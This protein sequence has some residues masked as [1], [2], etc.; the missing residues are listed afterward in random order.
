MGIQVGSGIKLFHCYILGAI[1][2]SILSVLPFIPG[3]GGGFVFDDK[4]NIVENPALQFSEL[5]VENL[6]YAA[7]SFYAGG[8]S[9]ALAMLTFALDHWRAGLDPHAFK[10]TNLLIHGLTTLV[11]AFFF[12]CI[13]LQ[14]QWSARRAAVAALLLA[15]VW[16]VHPLQVS[17]VLYVVQR[18]QTLG[19][20][21][22]ILAL[23]SYL[24]MRQLQI[25]GEFGRTFGLLSALLWAMALACK[26]D[27][28]LLPAYTL[29]LELTLLQFR[30]AGP[31]TSRNLKRLYLGLV[32]ASVVLFCVVIVPQHWQWHQYSGRDFSSMDR[33]LTQAR[34][35][36]MYLQQILLPLPSLMPFYYDDIL[37]SRG[38]TSPWTTLPSLLLLGALLVWAWCWRARRPI[39]SLG[40]FLFFAGH[41]ITSNIINLEMA[42]EHRNHFPLI[43]AVLAVADLLFYVLKRFGFSRGF[44]AISIMI[45]LLLAMV[46]TAMRSS[47]W[48]E[49]LKFAKAG[50]EMAPYSTRA[51][52]LL[53]GT[54]YDLYAETGSSRYLEMAIEACQDGANKT[55]DVTLLSNIVVFKTI[56]G[57]IEEQDWDRFLDELKVA[58][59]NA[60]NRN[61]LRVT[62]NNV[63]R[64]IALDERGVI[65]TI[66]II[67][68]RAQ[69]PQHELLR[70]AAYLF[71][72]T[73]EPIKAYGYFV[74]A[75][76]L[77]DLG[78]PDIERVLNQLSAAGRDDWVYK[79]RQIKPKN[80]L[81]TTQP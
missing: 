43:G 8:G 64:G 74:R 23:F 25:A 58:P 26:E 24:R 18:M 22:L 78:D 47:V 63:D 19:T 80:L 15:T 38:L 10:M 77:S 44:F 65:E 31:V 50:T 9:R 76:E 79:L 7:Y 69:L 60:Q 21:F 55:E 20:L 37:V 66:H 6:L 27:A 72:S 57:S 35:L 45:A 13:M 68:S 56:R 49:P 54:Y 53:C 51:W 40:I 67:S 17:S 42:F 75:I 11:L 61:V 1:L 81:E 29:A 62:L 70:A 34:V 30:A 39:F 5:S 59:M 14:A 33:L 32:I 73:H 52:L 12:R 46:S 41:F 28:A 16:A 71:N 36:V 2:C 48:G 3:L 4:P